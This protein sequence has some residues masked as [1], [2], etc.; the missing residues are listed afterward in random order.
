MTNT[1][2]SLE[3]YIFGYDKSI[4]VTWIGTGIPRSYGGYNGSAVEGV[5]ITALI[6]SE[7]PRDL[8]NITPI[9]VIEGKN[10][11]NFTHIY[12]KN[13]AFLHPEGSLLS[14]DI[15]LFGVWVQTKL[16]PKKTR[17]PQYSR[18]FGWHNERS[19]VRSPRCRICGSAQQL[20]SSDI[21]CTSGTV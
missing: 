10:T 21:S 5:S 1:I 16:L 6:I 13:W 12:Q 2:I 9:S 11:K 7:V 4:P 19:Y 14:R 18:C 20:E 17:A 3:V 15:P 8:T